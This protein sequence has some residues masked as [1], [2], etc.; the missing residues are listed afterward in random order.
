MIGSCLWGHAGG[1]CAPA[2]A[3][4]LCCRFKEAGMGVRLCHPSQEALKGMEREGRQSGEVDQLLYC[5]KPQFPHLKWH[6]TVALDA[7]RGIRSLDFVSLASGLHP[8]SHIPKVRM[9]THTSWRFA[10]RTQQ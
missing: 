1:D 7:L 10:V 4:L 2:R 6:D 3:Q 9:A 5:C 8:S